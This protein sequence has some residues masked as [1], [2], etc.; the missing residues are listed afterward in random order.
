MRMGVYGRRVQT[1]RMFL[2]MGIASLGISTGPARAAFIVRDVNSSG[3]LNS[4]ADADALLTG[5]NEQSETTAVM[6][7][8]DMIVMEAPN[9]GDGHFG[10]DLAFPNIAAGTIQFALDVTGSVVIPTAGTYTFGISTDDGAR[11]SLDT[12]AGL[13][14]VI[15]DDGPQPPTDRFAVV[16]FPAAGGYALDLTYFQEFGEGEIEL[17]A[18]PGSFASFNSTFQLVGDTASGGLA[19]T[20]VPEPASVGLLAIGAILLR[21]RVAVK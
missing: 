13:Q 14:T 17:F 15:T 10:N 6:P 8:V 21:R 4:L 1:T 7:F 18:A 19:T 16:T 3:T 12:G 2:A 20:S 11:L 9:L 5:V